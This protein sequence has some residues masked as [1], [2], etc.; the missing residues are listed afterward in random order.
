MSAKHWATAGVVVLGAA[1]AG[2]HLTKSDLPEGC[3]ESNAD[4]KLYVVQDG[5]ASTAN[6]AW[7]LAE[8][9]KTCFQREGGGS[10]VSIPVIQYP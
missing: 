5:K 7:T 10:F 1:W 3:F 9:K 6:P 8:D 4:N 2:V